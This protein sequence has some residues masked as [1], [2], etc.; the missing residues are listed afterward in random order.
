MAEEIIVI[1]DDSQ[2]EVSLFVS[3]GAVIGVTI[4]TDTGNE[5]DLSNI[6]GNLCNMASANTEAEFTLVN[7]VAGGSAL[8]L[9]KRATEP[10]ILEATKIF[11]DPFIPNIN[12]YIEVFNNGNKTEYEFKGIE[13]DLINYLK[14]VTDDGGIV[15]AL[16]C[17]G[18][19]D[20]DTVTYFSGY[21][22]GKIYSQV[23]TDGVDDYVVDRAGLRTRTDENGIIE[24][25]AN[26]V[27]A[28]EFRNGAACPV[29]S[30]ESQA[31]N[32]FLRSQEFDNSYWDKADSSITPNVTISPDGT[33][34]ADKL[35]ENSDNDDHFFFKG[36]GALIDD[37][38]ITIYAKKAERNYLFIQLD[39]PGSNANWFDLEN[40]LVGSQTGA[41]SRV[42]EVKDV[43]NGWFRCTV[44][45]NTPITNVRFGVSKDD[46]IAIYQGDGVSGVFV[47]QS[48]LVALPYATSPI[49]TEGSTQTRLKDVVENSGDINSFN[50]SE[51]VHFIKASALF[52]DGTDRVFSVSDETLD[53][54]IYISYTSVSNEIK[55]DVI[56]GGVSQALMTYTVAD[57]TVLT[58]IGIRGKLNDCSLWIDGIERATDTNCIMPTGLKNKSYHDGVGNNNFLAD[59]EIDKSFKEFL[60][61][62]QMFNLGTTGNI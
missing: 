27:P 54:R 59:I 25:L 41:T 31:L 51:W 7:V 38:T 40:G 34:N 6:L 3:D 32:L 14:R 24:T 43:G 29:L 61:D 26:N 62:T 58:S 60:T 33:Q 52:D 2:E 46:G 39:V 10:N 15:E 45:Y 16:E 57:V 30:L 50:D 28:L 22:A 4:T 42:S 17:I 35:V 21:K 19:L 13:F 9:V 18:A 5:I 55:V 48:D 20:A 36:V 53:E 11:G 8:V 47:W 1:V 49:F 12:N 23:G 44:T 56:A 37:Y